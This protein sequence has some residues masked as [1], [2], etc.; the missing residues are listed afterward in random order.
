LSKFKTHTTVWLIESVIVRL[1][2]YRF[3][4]KTNVWFLRL[5]T[6]HY[7]AIV[8]FVSIF[9]FFLYVKKLLYFVLHKVDL[10]RAKVFVFN[11]AWLSRFLP[12][13]HTARQP[14]RQLTRHPILWRLQ[15]VKWLLSWFPFILICP[16]NQFIEVWLLTLTFLKSRINVMVCEVTAVNWLW[17]NFN[18]LLLFFILFY[19][20]FQLESIFC[21]LFPYL[22]LLFFFKDTMVNVI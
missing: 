18:W 4:L 20:L 22:E 13:S 3:G 2:L 19:L 17:F 6:T 11:F 10:L 12:R 7:V 21:V 8:Y 5:W 9:S 16:W 14:R 1:R 15:W